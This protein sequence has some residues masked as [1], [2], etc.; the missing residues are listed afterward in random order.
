[1]KFWIKRHIPLFLFIICLLVLALELN[2]AQKQENQK[3]IQEQAIAI[4]IE[5][6][7]RVYDGNKFVDNLSIKDFVI[8]EDGKKQKVDAVY[9]IKERAI[10]RKEIVEEE[11]LT[12]K[13]ELEKKVSPEEQRHFIFVFDLLEYLP[14]I[15][16]VI[17]YFFQ[18]VMQPSDTVQVFTPVGNYR[19]TPESI[20]AKTKIE[21][22]DSLKNIVKKNEGQRFETH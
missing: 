3:D 15:N 14:Q 4:N 21:M 6:P 7:T 5:V 12:K 17:D 2:T 22:A 1:M 18:N 9:L 13:E 10:K 19:L 20:K 11:D 16:E 8:Y